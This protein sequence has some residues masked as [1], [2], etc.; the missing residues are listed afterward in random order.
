MNQLDEKILDDLKYYA[1]RRDVGSESKEELIDI[2]LN[3]QI[4]IQKLTFLHWKD[5][6]LIKSIRE[7]EE[8]Q[9][10]FFW[11]T[12]SPFSQWYKSFFTASVLFHK[13]I[14]NEQREYLSNSLP[15]ELEFSSAEQFMMYHKAL[16]FLDR[17]IADSIMKTSNPRKIK[18]LG[19]QVKNYDDNV[20]H[21]HRSD[22]VYAANLL[23][24][25][26]NQGIMGALADTMGT[27]LVEAAP[28]D[29]IWGIGLAADDPKAQQRETWEGKNLLGEILTQI[30]VELMGEY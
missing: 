5:K 12:Q 25:E 27:T 18:E 17:E 21:Y 13:G 15:K 10:T 20:W 26:Q 9:F 24:F 19:R 14:T 11:E 6:D 23:K 3:E 1:G 28:N 8:T 2:A 30:R 29:K 16:I 22:V 4:P 7:R